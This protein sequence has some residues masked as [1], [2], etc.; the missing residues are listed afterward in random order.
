[1]ISKV[2]YFSLLVCFPLFIYAQNNTPMK[3]I[4]EFGVLS[5]NNG[6]VNKENLQKAIDWAATRGAALF[7]EPTEEPYRVEGGI[8]LKQNVS[9]IGDSWAS[10][11]RN[12]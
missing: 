6:A 10:W 1:M 11:K 2:K 5:T 3:S 7:V 8:I 12:L 9:L 4:Q